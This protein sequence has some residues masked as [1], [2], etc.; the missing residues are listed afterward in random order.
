LVWDKGD[1]NVATAVDVLDGTSLLATVTANQFR[2][3]LLNIGKG[4]G[5]YG[6]SYTLPLAVK[7]GKPHS[8]RARVSPSGLDLYS[9]PK[10]ISC[11]KPSGYHDMANCN[12]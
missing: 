12:G 1:S 7:N 2:Q 9:S 8:I 3:D 11:A 4:N 10:T 6:F 5:Y